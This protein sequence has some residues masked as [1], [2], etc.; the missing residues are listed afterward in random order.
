MTFSGYKIGAGRVE[1][2]Q[3]INFNT[4]VFAFELE[5]V[6]PLPVEALALCIGKLKVGEA[7]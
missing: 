6:F 1:T 7:L 5:L 4:I 2:L 3:N